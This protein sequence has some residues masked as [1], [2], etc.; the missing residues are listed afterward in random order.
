CRVMADT[1]ALALTAF[2]LGLATLP[3]DMAALAAGCAFGAALSVKLTA[4]TAVPAL[5]WL[6]RNRAPIACAGFAAVVGLLLLA[7]ARALGDLWTSGV[8]YHDRARSTPAVIPH[9]VHQIFDQI[10]RSTPF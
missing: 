4:L 6:L 9:P 10:P 1:P 5:L 7:H 8:T 2:S 3:A